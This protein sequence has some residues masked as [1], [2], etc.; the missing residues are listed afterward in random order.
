MSG[1]DVEEILMSI[2]INLC[3]C[4]ATLASM[5]RISYLVVGSN[6]YASCGFVADVTC[7]G[8]VLGYGSEMPYV[9][10]WGCHGSISVATTMKRPTSLNRVKN[11]ACFK[12]IERDQ[13]WWSLCAIS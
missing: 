5:A 1:A 10:E 6:E 8:R 7:F 2:P 11:T 12:N 9:W 3:D 13:S 4:M